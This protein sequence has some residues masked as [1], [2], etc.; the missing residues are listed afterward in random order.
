[1]EAGLWEELGTALGLS[2]ERLE[3]IA[4]EEEADLEKRKQCILH[5]SLLSE[6]PK[7]SGEVCVLCRVAVLCRE[8]VPL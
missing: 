3:K 4:L 1:M 2:S 5:V 7:H 8:A 6:I